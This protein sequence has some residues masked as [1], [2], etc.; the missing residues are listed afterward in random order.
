M[1]TSDGWGAVIQGEPAD[2]S[3]W[4]QTLKHQFDVWVEIHGSETVLRATSFDESES[5]TE[6]R[7]R[8]I[9]YI[10]RLNGLMALSHADSEPVRLQ[11][12]I[13]FKDG[14]LHRHLIPGTGKFKARGSMITD[15]TVIGA[16]GKPVPPSAP[17]PSEVQR[18]LTIAD[19]EDLLN[20]ALNY[21]GRVP[22][23]PAGP[24]AGH[25]GTPAMEATEWFDIYKALECIE[26]RFGGDETA[27][28]NFAS[29]RNWTSRSKLELL[30]RTAN[31]ARHARRKFD[32]PPNPMGFKEA[33]ELLGQL[34]RRALEE[35]ANQP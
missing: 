35:A 12:V 26:K 2:L 27:F 5:S 15:T 29:D 18:W 28:R 25:A 10:N 9:A 19:Q 34:L 13:R 23:S 30:K 21:F 1:A 7:D 4:Q 3:I 20:D 24:E 11:A 8:A 14:H 17:E 33:R 22:Q 6:V 32:P 16:N 31:W